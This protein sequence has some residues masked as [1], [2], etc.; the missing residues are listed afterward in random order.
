[1]KRKQIINKIT[2]LLLFSCIMGI[3]AFA[4]S[5]YLNGI[6]FDDARGRAFCEFVYEITATSN[7]PTAQGASYPRWYFDGIEDT[8]LRGQGLVGHSSMEMITKIFMPGEHTVKMELL[9]ANNT[10][11]ECVTTFNVNSSPTIETVTL[12]EFCNYGSFNLTPPA[13]TGGSTL[14][15][16]WQLETG[17]GS[18]EY[19]NINVPYKLSSSDNGKRIRYYVENVCGVAYSNFQTMVVNPTVKPAVEILV[20]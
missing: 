8:D 1:M 10:V 3:N 7:L 19:H 20:K 5:A 17:V 16:G 11:K 13:V 14:F 4:Q 18:N 15:E 9:D 6:H 12:P 2:L